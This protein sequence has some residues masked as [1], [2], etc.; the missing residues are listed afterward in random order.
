MGFFH[1]S[2]VEVNDEPNELERLLLTWE[3][4]F[5]SNGEFI[6]RAINQFGVFGWD[7][8]KSQIAWYERKDIKEV[9]TSENQS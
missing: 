4:G 2:L 3:N 5:L 7:W 9:I 1:Q 6:G 8:A